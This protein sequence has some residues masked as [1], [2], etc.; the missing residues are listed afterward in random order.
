MTARQL[1]LTAEVLERFKGI[2]SEPEAPVENEEECFYLCEDCG[3]AVDPREIYQV[4]W[5][6]QEEHERLPGNA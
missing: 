5:H 4:L 3:Q 2:R 1:S 6:E